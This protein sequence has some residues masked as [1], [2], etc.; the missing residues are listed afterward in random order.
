MLQYISEL[1]WWKSQSVKEVNFTLT[2]AQHW[3]A[4]LPAKDYN[5]VTPSP[6]K[7]IPKSCIFLFY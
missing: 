7:K 2:P 1:S 5:K 6:H 3:S 4:R